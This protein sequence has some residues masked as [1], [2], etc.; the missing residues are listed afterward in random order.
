MIV[1]LLGLLSAPARA[2]LPPPDYREAVAEAAGVEV[3]RRAQEEGAQ[4]AEDFARSYTR[5]IGPSAA[6]AYEVGLAW[7]LAGEE[8]KARRWL[9]A[10]IEADPNYAAARYDRG[11]ILLNQGE[12]D[13]AE[14]DFLEVVRLQPTAWVGYFRLADVAGRRKDAAVF[15]TRLLE[16]L[17]WGFTLRTVVGDPRW[18]GYFADP[19]L[20]PVLQKL[21]TVYQDDSLLEELGAPL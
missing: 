10:A 16:A 9:D 18:H 2:E 20:G 6:V 19:E 21:I 5:Q 13:A 14:K 15:E 17:R 12:I 4:A 3:S 8:A 7:R 11:E 1:L